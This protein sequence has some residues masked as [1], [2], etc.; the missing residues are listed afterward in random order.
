M[1]GTE[2]VSRRRRVL[3]AAVIAV[4]VVLLAAAT[5]GVLVGTRGP[6]RE[7]PA[8]VAGAWAESYAAGDDRACELATAEFAPELESAGHCGSGP[9]ESE[10]SD[11]RVLYAQP[12]GTDALAG[13]ADG[14]AVFG[15]PYALLGMDRSAE[16]EWAVDSVTPLSDREGLIPGDCDSE[17]D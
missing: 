10:S 3:V 14:D 15:K 9:G 6:D 1:R 2:I 13:I 7:D 4:A 12:C 17:G 11:V 8:A 5:A 16:G